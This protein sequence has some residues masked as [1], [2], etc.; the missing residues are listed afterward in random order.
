MQLVMDRCEK[1]LV[2]RCLRGKIAERHFGFLDPLVARD[3]LLLCQRLGLKDLGWY[4]AYDLG[5]RWGGGGCAQCL[6]ARHRRRAAAPVPCG[7]APPLRP[8]QRRHLS[9]CPCRSRTLPPPQAVG[10]PVARPDAR[11]P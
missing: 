11:L 4:C 8:A 5:C 10:R 2:S 1:W 7:C 9:P 3:W 6:E